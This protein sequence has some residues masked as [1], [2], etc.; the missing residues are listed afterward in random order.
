MPAIPVKAT[1]RS[2]DRHRDYR[3]P[4][5]RRSMHARI[6]RDLGMRIVTGAYMMLVRLTE[7]T[8]VDI[9]PPLPPGAFDRP[10]KAG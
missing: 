10:A 1:G 2:P 7:T 8:D 9:E 4:P 3:H 5:E 6:V